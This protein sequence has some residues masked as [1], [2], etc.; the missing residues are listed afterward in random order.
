MKKVQI[1]LSFLM[2]ANSFAVH[3]KIDLRY[4]KKTPQY[5]NRLVGIVGRSIVATVALS[6]AKKTST[7]TVIKDLDKSEFYGRAKKAKWQFTPK[8]WHKIDFDKPKL[9]WGVGGKHDPKL[10]PY[11]WKLICVI[12][13][14]EKDFE[15]KTIEEKLW[16]HEDELDGEEFE[17]EI[18]SGEASKGLFFMKPLSLMYFFTK[19]FQKK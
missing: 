14:S 6:K 12:N 16:V 11:L 18:E 3:I 2:V 17:E 19:F 7:L 4:C 1:I 15:N 13:Q 10:A 9:C 8:N 5:Y